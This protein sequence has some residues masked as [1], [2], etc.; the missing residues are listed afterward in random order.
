MI[1]GNADGAQLAWDNQT[2]NQVQDQTQH[3]APGFELIAQAV[4]HTLENLPLLGLSEQDQ[5]DAEDA[6]KEVLEEVTQDEPKPGR[7]RR[8]LS[9][10]KWFLTPVATGV[11]T[12]AGEGAQEWAKTA[13]E[14]LSVPF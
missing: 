8:A 12:G 5:Q 4:A 10:I 6:A 14:H 2:V 1:Y 11:A 7:I 9:A 13:I 3:I